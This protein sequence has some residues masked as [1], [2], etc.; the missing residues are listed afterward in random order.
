MYI[1]FYYNY[2]ITILDWW[3]LKPI[4][5]QWF[6]KPHTQIYKKRVSKFGITLHVMIARM[7]KLMVIFS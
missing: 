3:N 7:S 4:I 2:H 1:L 6:V 5:Y